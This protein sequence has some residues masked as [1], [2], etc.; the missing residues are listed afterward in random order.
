MGETKWWIDSRQTD[1]SLVI[2]LADGTNRMAIRR[3]NV[4]TNGTSKA[5][6]FVATPAFRRCLALCIACCFALIVARPAWAA[7]MVGSGS[8]G[9][10]DDNKFA[11]AL[12]NG[13]L[14]TFNC[15]A[16]PF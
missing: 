14:V 6:N 16:N 10:C 5:R 15:G 13:G 9:T 11:T 8:P 12:T 4:G 7:G 2:C 1:S 3:I